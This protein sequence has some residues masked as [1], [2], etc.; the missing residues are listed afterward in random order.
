MSEIPTKSA[1]LRRATHSSVAISLTKVIFRAIKNKGV[2]QGGL[3][4]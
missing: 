3:N 4:G 2:V 1:A